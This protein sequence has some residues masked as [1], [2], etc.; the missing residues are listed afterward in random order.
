MQEKRPSAVPVLVSV[1]LTFCLY[2]WAII[3]PGWLIIKCTR[4]LPVSVHKYNPLV[5]SLLNGT[6][7]TLNTETIKYSLEMS[8]FYVNECD[9]GA[10]IQVDYK[11]LFIPSESTNSLPDLMEIKIEGTSVLD[12]CVIGFFFLL[13]NFGNSSRVVTGGLCVLLAA[14]VESI[15]VYRMGMANT[16]TSEFLDAIDLSWDYNSISMDFPYSIVIASI[17]IYSNVIVLYLCVDLYTKIRRQQT[18]DGRKL[19]LCTIFN[20]NKFTILRESQITE[21]HHLYL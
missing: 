3:T 5:R 15:M 1:S 8:I 12:F 16:T 21:M 6:S 18:T 11:K 13:L 17:G 20:S 2:V 4:V 10:C 7:E 9:S 19:K 14:V